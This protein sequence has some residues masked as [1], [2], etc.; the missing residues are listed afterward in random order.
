[1]EPRARGDDECTVHGGFQSSRQQR[2][3][4]KWTVR[5][6]RTASQRAASDGGRFV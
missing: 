2:G 6:A 1:M 5:D 4:L 3:F